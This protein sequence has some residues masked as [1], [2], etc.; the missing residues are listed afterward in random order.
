MHLG[1][2]YEA[3]LQ[4]ENKAK[5]KILAGQLL[6]RLVGYTNSN[7]TGNLKDQKLIMEHCFFIYK[8]ILS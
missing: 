8:V 1:L 4:S 7:Y 2:I 3:H 5:V 6:F